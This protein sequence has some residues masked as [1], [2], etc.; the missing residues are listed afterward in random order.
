MKVGIITIFDSENF[1]NKLQNYALHQILSEYADE[2]VTIRNKPNFHSLWECLRRRTALAESVWLNRRIGKERKAKIL[3]FQK[4]YIPTSRRSYCC[5]KSYRRLKPGERCDLYCI[6]SDQVWNPELGRTGGFTYGSFAGEAV[7]SYAASF[8]VE[9]I[10]EK[11]RKE[12]GTWLSQIPHI[13]L[14]E[15]AGQ[16]IVGEL[17]G[18]EDARVHI[19]PTMLLPR[20]AWDSIARKP[21]EP[22]PKSYLLLYFLGGLTPKHRRN[23]LQKAAQL[24]LEIVEL[25][26]TSSPFYES[27]PEEFL[28]LVQNAALVYTDSFH[29]SVFSFLFRRPF[30][31][32]PRKGNMGSRMETFTRTFCLESSMATGETIPEVPLEADYSERYLTLEAERERAKEYLN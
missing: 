17:T 8:G 28:C 12:I 32:F 13:S 26:E 7:F 15:Q 23:I 30:V 11:Y 14:R 20:E 3:Q 21:K 4:T 27:G 1:G 25:M 19:D 6:G 29:A 10:P 16:S 24:G 2:V 18:R 31:I 5:G 22:L 9:E